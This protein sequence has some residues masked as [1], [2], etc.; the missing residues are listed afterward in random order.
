MFERYTEPA[1]RVLFFARYESSQ[2][3]TPSIEPSHIL[4]GILREEKG[5]IRTIFSTQRVT[6]E[7]VRKH[8]ERVTVFQEE[9]PLSVEIPFAQRS[10]RLLQYAAEEADRLAHHGIGRPHMLLGLLMLDDEPLASYLADQGVTLAG[11]RE[12]VRIGWAADED[13]R[14]SDAD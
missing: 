1:R 12:D 4:L 10:K 7:Q 8:I 11:T 13:E 5:L 2:I 9:Y 14:F 3:G 6:P